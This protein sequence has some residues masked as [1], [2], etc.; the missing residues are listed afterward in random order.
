[1]TLRKLLESCRY[2]D[3]FNILYREYYLEEK[4]EATHAAALGYRKVV[5][6]LLSLPQKINKEYKIYIREREDD[7]PIDV[8]LYC[9]E[10]DEFYAID[11]T[12]W[13]D[14]IDAKIKNDIA[15]DNCTTLAH[16]LWEITFYGYSEEE[17]SLEKDNLKRMVERIDSGEEELVPWE[18]VLK[19]IE[20]ENENEE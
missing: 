1:M 12:P 19:D 3:V 5:E 4:S 6:K 18:E 11:L 20:E 2:K 10:D 7:I 15:L 13:G 14:L 9:N 8:G 17:I 16:I